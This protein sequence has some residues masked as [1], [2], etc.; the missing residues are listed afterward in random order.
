M[1]LLK[2][3]RFVDKF[4]SKFGKEEGRVDILFTCL[5]KFKRFVEKLK[6]KFLVKKRRFMV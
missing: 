2:F 1:Y 5:L 3:K 6:C 4:K